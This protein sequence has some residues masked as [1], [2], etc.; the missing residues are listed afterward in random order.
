[1]SK[2]CLLIIFICNCI[3][4]LQAQHTRTE[5]LLF[6]PDKPDS[7]FTR[8]HIENYLSHESMV[9]RS[10]RKASIRHS[11]LPVSASY[12]EVIKDSGFAV[13]NKSRWFN[14]VQVSINDSINHAQQKVPGFVDSIIIFGSKKKRRVAKTKMSTSTLEPASEDQFRQV[15]IDIMHS[16]GYYGAG[17]KIAVMDAG[18]SG[19]DTIGAFR[20]LFENNQVNDSY[21]FVSDKSDPY[22]GGS[23]GTQVMGILGALSNDYTGAACSSHF[24]LYRTE[25]VGSESIKEEFN[26]TFAA[27]RA[28]SLG[29][30][31]INTSLGYNEFDD[32]STNYSY[33]NM[34]GNT[35]YITRAANHA[36]AAGIVV[37]CSAGNEGNSPWQHILAPADAIDAIAV[38]AVNGSG[39]YESFSSRGP[40]SDFRI[41][42]DICARG[43]AVRT[44]NSSGELSTASGTSFAAPIISGLMA[45]VLQIDSLSSVAKLKG[46]VIATANNYTS[47]DNNLGYGIPNF[48]GYFLREHHEGGAVILDDV[49]IFPNPVCGDKLFINVNGGDGHLAIKLVNMNGESQE[50][51]FDLNGTHLLN[52]DVSH[53]IPGIYCLIINGYFDKSV[54]FVKM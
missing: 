14:A 1:M 9:R 37:V 39:E 35:T 3:S 22:S 42:P 34:D 19:L 45:G 8:S 50:Q 52:M 7:V 24:Y 11:D 15:G 46:K 32:V 10:K 27:E 54:R 6:L 40:T 5:M 23:H 47:P 43:I 16:L 29:V 38:G 31:L 44:F 48:S 51:V 18:F 12:L 30:D 33:E 13:L 53:L 20:H 25:D 41:K 28:D 49:L 36:T 2:F 26:W 17:I 4:S 21:D